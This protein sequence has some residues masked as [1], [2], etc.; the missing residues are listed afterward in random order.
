MSRQRELRRARLKELQQQLRGLLAQLGPAWVL[1][2]FWLLCP[3]LTGPTLVAKLGATADWLLRQPLRGVPQWTAVMGLVIGLGLLPAYA[4]TILC[5]WVYGAG[6]GFASAMSSYLLAACLSHLIARKVSFHRVDPLIARSEQAQQVRRALLHS[7][8]GRALLIVSLFRLTG[9]PYPAGT[10]VLTSCG[11]TLRQNLL[12]AM[13]GTA[14]RIA[15]GA[16][17][18]SRFAATGARDIQA[19]LSGNDSL[20]RL[21]LGLLLGL[22]LLAVIAQISRRALSQLAA[23]TPAV[24]PGVGGAP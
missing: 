7:S 16:L 2:A 11:V 17:I 6:L 9:F 22:A 24:E 20:L 12:G 23:E 5:G 18:A 14:P 8:P 1:L 21:G 3:L 10:L 15:T 19:V 4:N 13:G